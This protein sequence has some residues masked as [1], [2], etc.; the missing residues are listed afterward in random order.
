MAPQWTHSGQFYVTQVNKSDSS[1]VNRQTYQQ[2]RALQG[3]GRG[4]VRHQGGRRGRRRD[5]AHG[6]ESL[7]GHREQDEPLPV[8]GS[9]IQG[10]PVTVQV[11][12]MTFST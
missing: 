1:G 2:E 6:R 10:V 7:Q 11:R 9:G 8:P 4:S 3:A 5:A 12:A